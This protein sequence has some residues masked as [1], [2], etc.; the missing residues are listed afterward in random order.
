MLSTYILIFC[1][2]YLFPFFSIFQFITSVHLY[3]M[4]YKHKI[5]ERNQNPNKLKYI[6]FSR[7]KYLNSVRNTI[8]LLLLS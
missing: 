6:L 4:R 8:I 7:E 5:L 3:F 1:I 2:F